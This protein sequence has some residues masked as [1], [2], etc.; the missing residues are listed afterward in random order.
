MVFP[1]DTG[2][3]ERANQAPLTLDNPD[4][5]LEQEEMPP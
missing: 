3:R 5:L 2:P 1:A 4:A